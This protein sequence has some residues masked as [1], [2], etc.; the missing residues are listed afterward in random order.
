MAQQQG[1]PHQTTYRPSHRPCPVCG[2]TFIL[3][4]ASRAIA[5]PDAAS[6]LTAPPASGRPLG[7]WCAF[8]LVLPRLSLAGLAVTRRRCDLPIPF[9]HTRPLILTYRPPP[10][11]WSQEHGAGQGRRWGWQGW[12]GWRCEGT[13]R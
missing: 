12:D 1:K 9:S 5:Q 13:G 2:T 7:Y 6:R 8:F 4:R 10:E 3:A 11:G